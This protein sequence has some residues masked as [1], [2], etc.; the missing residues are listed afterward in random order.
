MPTPHV[1]THSSS[2]FGLLQVALKCADIGHLACPRAVHRRWVKCLEEELFRQGDQERSNGLPISPLMDRHKAGI[3]K[4]QTGFFDI[5]AL[6]M[7]QS[8]VQV[9]GRRKG[10]AW[11]VVK[12]G[13]GEDASSCRACVGDGKWTGGQQGGG[14]HWESERGREGRTHGAHTCSR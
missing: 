1:L 10:S 5:V 13:R 6:P 11:W 4:S 12:G 8:F 14:T 9:R 3:T 2:M 7:Y